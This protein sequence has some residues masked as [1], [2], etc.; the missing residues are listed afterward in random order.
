VPRTDV[1]A[2]LKEGKIWD[3]NAS[4]WLSKKIGF[5]MDAEEHMELLG[6]GRDAAKKYLAEALD[7]NVPEEWSPDKKVTAKRAPR[8]KAS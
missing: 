5:K 6:E 1:I 2:V 7:P 8:K 4:T 3:S